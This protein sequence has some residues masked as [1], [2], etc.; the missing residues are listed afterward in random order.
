MRQTIALFLI[1]GFL[2]I[3][4]AGLA[5]NPPHPNGGNAPGAGNTPVGGGSPLD[6]GL[7]AMLLMGISFALYKR[8][9]KIKNKK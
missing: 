2:V 4:F 1:T 7:S 3:A 9:Q 8:T 5:Q 6:G